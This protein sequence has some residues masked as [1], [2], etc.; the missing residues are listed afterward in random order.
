MSACNCMT[1]GPGCC[2]NRAV[3]SA[4]PWFS[5]V[6]YQQPSTLDRQFVT[7]T[8]TGGPMVE[9]QPSRTV[10]TKPFETVTDDPLNP[11]SSPL[12]GA[13]QCPGCGTIYSM[14]VNSCGC[15]Q[16]RWVESSTTFK[17]YPRK[18]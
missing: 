14:S 10:P 15:Q 11:V 5:V 17:L 9:P 8:H 1:N 4:M 6:P 2:R 3:L 13:W 18:E 12:A 7:T 16:H